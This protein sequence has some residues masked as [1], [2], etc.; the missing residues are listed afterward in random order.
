MVATTNIF[1]GRRLLVLLSVLLVTGFFATTFGSY[2]VSRSVIREAI[3]GRELPLA[4]SN[5]Y[6]ELQKDLVE[7]L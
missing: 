4:S 7:P 3:I 5:I 1:A 2:L 6:V